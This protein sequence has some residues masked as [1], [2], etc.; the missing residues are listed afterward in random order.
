MILFV[1]DKKPGSWHLRSDICIVCHF[2]YAGE[3]KGFGLSLKPMLTLTGCLSLKE[4]ILNF[5][6]PLCHASYNAIFI[7]ASSLEALEVP[8]DLAGCSYTV[9]T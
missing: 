6:A 5:K 8:H 3:T 7:P 9:D 2:I 4:K 1:L